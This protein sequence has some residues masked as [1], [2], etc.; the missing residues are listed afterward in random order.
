MPIITEI[1]IEK[2]TLYTFVG[3]D[4]SMARLSLKNRQ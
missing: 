1:P 3:S 2:D 4:C